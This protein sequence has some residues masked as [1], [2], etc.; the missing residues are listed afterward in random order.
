[1]N[2][3]YTSTFTEDYKTNDWALGQHDTADMIPAETLKTLIGYLNNAIT[4]VGEDSVY[5]EHINLLK[6]LPRYVCLRR[7]GDDI[8]GVVGMEAGLKADML[9]CNTLAKT[10]RWKVISDN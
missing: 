5:A 4:A 7:Y 8:S 2:A 6:F 10:L 3:A 1:M 9:A